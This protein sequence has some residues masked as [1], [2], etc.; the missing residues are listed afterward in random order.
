MN[1]CVLCYGTFVNVFL[2]GNKH[3][4]SLEAVLRLANHNF[5]LLKMQNNLET[6]LFVIFVMSVGGVM[7]IF[8]FYN[9]VC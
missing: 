7:Q 1:V 2:L 8:L 4:C 9:L 5:S 6:L 3:T